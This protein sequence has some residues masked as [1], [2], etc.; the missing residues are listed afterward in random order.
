MQTILDKIKAPIAGEMTRFQDI[1]AKSLSDQDGLLQEVLSH[2][3]K[4]G[5]KRMRPILTLLIAKA[6]NAQNQAY[7]KALY[8][9]C[10]L[11]LLH[12]ASLVHD[13]VVDESKERRGQLSVNAVYNNRLAVLVG[14]FV[15]STSLKS[16]A[17]CYNSDMTNVVADLG[18]ILSKGEVQ[19]I[20]NIS[21]NYFDEGAYFDI[22][23]KK[24]AS[25]FEACCKLGALSV[26]ATEEQLEKASKF[27]HDVGIIFQIRDDIFDYYDSKEIGKPTGNDMREG[28]LTLPVLSVLNNTEHPVSEE[29]RQIALKVKRT[30]ASDAEIAQ[31]ITYTKDNGGIEAAQRVMEDYYKNAASFI[32]ND[33]N[34]PELKSSLKT[35]L[36]YVVGRTH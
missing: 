4:R 18:Q 21:T 6:F 29:I 2:I 11:E 30:E 14:D 33:I 23:S 20:Q 22:I 13:D 16:V 8:A 19:Q 12:T 26:C 5:G 35:Y 24:T 9:A 7:D 17:M 36:D 27:G 28:K 31:I 25:L 1:F 10:A 34:D 3:T 32:D 15:L